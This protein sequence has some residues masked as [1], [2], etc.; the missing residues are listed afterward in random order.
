MPE[1]EKVYGGKER[2]KSRPWL[3][4]SLLDENETNDSEVESAK[5][6][7]ILKMEDEDKGTIKLETEAPTI[8]HNQAYRPV[9]DPVKEAINA[10]MSGKPKRLHKYL[11]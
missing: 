7:D 4:P 2:K 6:K 8:S 3:R 1:D 5:P 11:G 10:N 9:A